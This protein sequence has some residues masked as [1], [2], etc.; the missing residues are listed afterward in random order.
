MDL[1]EDPQAYHSDKEI[2]PSILFRRFGNC[3][4]DG[5]KEKVLENYRKSVCLNGT[6]SFV[7]GNSVYCIL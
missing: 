2:F 4:A 5:K 1:G 7:F 6:R 3:R